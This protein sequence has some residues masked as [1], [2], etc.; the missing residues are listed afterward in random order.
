MIVI[1]ALFIAGIVVGAS[2]LFSGIFMKKHN[3]EGY[4]F[5]DDEVWKKYP[6]KA[7]VGSIV[8]GLHKIF[9]FWAVRLIFILIGVGVIA[10]F[11]SM[12]NVI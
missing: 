11:L 2:I 8:M 5:N 10:L 9:P 1:R 7:L 6:M 12:A 3:F 4:D